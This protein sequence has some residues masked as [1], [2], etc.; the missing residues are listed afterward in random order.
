[1]SKFK[2][3][4]LNKLIE[5]L[6][7][8]DDKYKK[9]VFVKEYKTDCIYEIVDYYINEDGDIILETGDEV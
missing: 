7:K 6:K 1:M 8:E 2:A 3:I 5:K 9:Q 4:K